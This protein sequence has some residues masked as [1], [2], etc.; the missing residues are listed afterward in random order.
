MANN[1]HSISY[2]S[3]TKKDVDGFIDVFYKNL[4]VTKTCTKRYHNSQHKLA[5]LDKSSEMLLRF[6]TEEM[7][8]SNSILHSH[9]LRKKFNAH[10]EKDCG[11]TYQ[12][13]TIKKAFAKLVKVKLLIRYGEKQMY[14]VN[15]IHYFNG[16]ESERKKLI[17]QLLKFYIDT[18]G[19]RNG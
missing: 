9:Y 4:K 13:D 2:R 15:P 16:T 8:K 17:G 3:G 12:D 7:D 18:E 6:I 10:M 14:T 1:Y 5:K 19:H 11:K